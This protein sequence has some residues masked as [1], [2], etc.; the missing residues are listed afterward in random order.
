[1]YYRFSVIPACCLTC[2]NLIFTD[3]LALCHVCCKLSHL[4]N[5]LIPKTG[6]F[7]LLIEL[8]VMWHIKLNM[9]LV[10]IHPQYPNFHPTNTAVHQIF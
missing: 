2:S 9:E 4:H 7:H 1:M 8:E 3:N 6:D 10:I 5:P